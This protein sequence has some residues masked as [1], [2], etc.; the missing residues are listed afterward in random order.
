MHTV[1]QNNKVSMNRSVGPYQSPSISKKKKNNNKKLLTH[2]F[3]HLFIQQIFF[4]CP[5]WS[6]TGLVTGDTAGSKQM[7]VPNFMKLVFEV[8][9]RRQKTNKLIIYDIS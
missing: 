6:D 5:L 1:S 4:T 3:I 9:G 7:E 8:G 2:S